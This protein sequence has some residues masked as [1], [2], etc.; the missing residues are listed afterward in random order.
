MS[1][2]QGRPLDA[3]DGLFG[4]A[5]TGNARTAGRWHGPQGDAT[6]QGHDREDAG[7]GDHADRPVRRRP[8]RPS[9]APATSAPVLAAAA[10]TAGGRR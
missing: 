4:L 3:P 8:A 1:R 5:R 9:P 10:G 6:G 2:N 7:F